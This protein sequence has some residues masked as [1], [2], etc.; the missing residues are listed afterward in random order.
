MTPRTSRQ[1]RICCRRGSARLPEG[2]SASSSRAACCGRS[3]A[4]GR[5]RRC[6]RGPG[7]PGFDHLALVALRHGFVIAGGEARRPGRRLG[8]EE[9]PALR[10]RGLRGLP[11][12]LGSWLRGGGGPAAH[13]GMPRGG[14]AGVGD[15][16]LPVMGAEEA[17]HQDPFAYP[18]PLLSVPASQRACQ[19]DVQSSFIL[20]EVT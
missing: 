20:E 3:R 9:P 10:P 17:R 16:S 1:P 15:D 7:Q 8:G 13:Q 14:G 18:P 12:R 4:G 11:G 5:F 19:Q 2:R 6:G